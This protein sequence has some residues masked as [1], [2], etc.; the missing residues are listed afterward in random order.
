MK[1]SNQAFEYVGSLN[2]DTAYIETGRKKV[3]EYFQKQGLPVFDK[4]IDF[5]VE[6][7]GLTLT[8]YNKPESSFNTKLYL[9]KDIE[10]N[11][12]VDFLKIEGRYF[13]YC[14]DHETAQFWFV[15]SQDGEVGIYD[16]NA[17]TVNL[18]FS[19]FEKFIETYAFEDL[20]SRNE[21]YEH[22][23]FYGLKDVEGFNN[24]TKEYFFSLLSD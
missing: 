1:L 4:V 6:Y 2:R 17:E 14:G 5:Q 24:Q 19:S 9:A 3:I 7:S 11:T 13:F 22:P 23:P 10:T 18:I 21:K 15:L 16:N 20:L 12:P 8:I